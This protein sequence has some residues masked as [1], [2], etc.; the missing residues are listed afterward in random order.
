MCRAIWVSRRIHASGVAE[1]RFGQARSTS[2]DPLE[3]YPRLT[4]VRSLAEIPAGHLGGYTAVQATVACYGSSRRANQNLP[5]P[6]IH[7]FRCIAR[8]RRYVSYSYQPITTSFPVPMPSSDSSPSDADK[9]AG[10]RKGWRGEL[11]RAVE[12]VMGWF[13]QSQRPP[14]RYVTKLGTLLTALLFLSIGVLV[15][16]NIVGAWPMSVPASVDVSLADTLGTVTPAE[17]DSLEARVARAALAMIRDSTEAGDTIRT[18]VFWWRIDTIGAPWDFRLLLIALW[19]GALGSLLH[20][21]SSFVSFAGNRQL[22]VSWLPWY[23]VRPLLGAGLAGVFYVVMRAGFGTAGGAAP[24]DVSHYTVA[25]FAALVGLFTHRA[26]LKLKDVFDA[27]FPPREEEQDADALG[28]DS[29]V[30]APRITSLIPEEVTVGTDAVPVEI[31]A[32]YTSDNM[33]LAVDG[34]ATE[35]T[36]LPNGNLEFVL[37]AGL[38]AEEG[39]VELI[40]KGKAGTSEPAQLVIAP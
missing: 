2:R 15:I 16:A 8:K 24:V 32:D 4:A 27:L 19:F 25:A 12:A 22:V 39:T 35:F 40:L 11:K 1:R 38:R 37:E 10:A 5:R 34:E 6:S 18:Y 31:V 36:R 20:A 17:I 30:A 28:G 26:T 13:I 29:S 14:K 3:E 7:D 21:G 9:H 23:I 33:M